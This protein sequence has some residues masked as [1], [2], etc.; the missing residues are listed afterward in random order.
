MIRAIIIAKKIGYKQLTA[1]LAWILTTSEA[2]A[3]VIEITV[4]HEQE[5][6]VSAKEGDTIRLKLPTILGT[7]YAWS[8]TGIDKGVYKEL[9]RE[10]FQSAT[11][12][13]FGSLSYKIYSFE[14]LHSQLSRLVFAY[15]APV[16]EQDIRT[17]VLKIVKN[18]AK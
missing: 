16:A 2:S 9:G 15:R 18:S 17:Y 6:T 4:S 7:G 8:I 13:S 12:P 1:L 14:V 10:Q 3:K 5:D 11:A